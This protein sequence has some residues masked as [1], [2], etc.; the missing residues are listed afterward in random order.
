VSTCSKK[1]CEGRKD[2]VHFTPKG[3]SL[4]AAGLEALI[5]EKRS[6]EKEAEEKAER[7]PAKKAK[8]D[9]TKKR[10]DWVKGSVS[11]A[12]RSSEVNRGSWRGNKLP[13]D[14]KCGGE[15]SAATAAV[16]APTETAAVATAAAEAAMTTVAAEGAQRLEAEAATGAAATEAGA[17]AALG[18]IEFDS[19]LRLCLSFVVVLAYPHPEWTS[20]FDLNIYPHPEWIVAP[21]AKMKKNYDEYTSF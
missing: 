5:Y 21:R 2:P 18:E 4:A 10:P 6:E 16:V 13:Q 17:E 7:Q 11:E 3:Y 12:V 1:S 20:I 19:V 15:V 14:S 9:L 8:F